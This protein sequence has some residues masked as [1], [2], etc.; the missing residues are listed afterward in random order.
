MGTEIIVSGPIKKPEAYGIRSTLHRKQAAGPRVYVD[1][2]R[3]IQQAHAEWLDRQNQKR[4]Y[5]LNGF[6][7]LKA[8]R[9]NTQ[10]RI[11][12]GMSSHHRAYTPRPFQ[13]PLASNTAYFK[14]KRT[15]P[16]REKWAGLEAYNVRPQPES[17]EKGKSCELG[18][19]LYSQDESESCDEIDS[20]DEMENNSDK[21]WPPVAKEWLKKWKYNDPEVCCIC[22]VETCDSI[23][24]FVYCDEPDCDVIVHQECYGINC[25][26]GPDETWRCDRCAALKLNPS[27]LIICALCP[28]SRGAFRKLEGP[29]FGMGWVHITCALWIPGVSISDKRTITGINLRSIKQSYWKGKCIVCKDML[30]AEYGAFVSCE[31][32]GCSQTFHVTCGLKYTLARKTI[33]GKNNIRCYEH[34]TREKFRRVRPEQRM[35]LWDRW[36]ESRDDYL[37][38]ADGTLNAKKEFSSAWFKAYKN[39]YSEDDPESYA[40]IYDSFCGELETICTRRCEIPARQIVQQTE[41]IT[42]LYKQIQDD[43]AHGLSISEKE[44]NN[45]LTSIQHAVDV[46]RRSKRYYEDIIEQATRLSFKLSFKPVSE[47]KNIPAVTLTRKPSNNL[48][49]RQR[50]HSTVE[51]SVDISNKPKTS[52]NTLKK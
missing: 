43:P 24:P 20:G 2:Q 31:E 45:I 21:K 27:K 9:Y 50:S 38:T 39:G 37:L 25:C 26:P 14:P 34:D 35:N 44:V 46:S 28:S 30:H 1:R 17:E 10:Q 7:G 3:I 16:V 6:D 18:N 12:N 19:D 41:M 32:T 8:Q 42:Q 11:H 33:T 22:Y 23:N 51:P 40:N 5:S 47:K 52:L 15:L 13:R 48:K 49:S 36:A 29:F 4:T